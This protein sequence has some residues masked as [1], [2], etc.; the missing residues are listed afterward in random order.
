MTEQEEKELWAIDTKLNALDAEFEAWQEAR[1]NVHGNLSEVY[2]QVGGNISKEDQ[3]LAERQSLINRKYEIE[4]ASDG[5]RAYLDSKKNKSQL[6]IS[7]LDNAK[8]DNSLS[9][10]GG[11]SL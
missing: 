6:E 1:G 11:K 7:K 10:L 8:V 2:Q 5:V 4:G 3:Y 9:P